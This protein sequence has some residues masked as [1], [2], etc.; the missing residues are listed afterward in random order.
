MSNALV[1]LRT[2][3]SEKIVLVHVESMSFQISRDLATIPIP[4]FHISSIPQATQQ[5]IEDICYSTQGHKF[6]MCP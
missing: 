1:F 5:K 4:N 2:P 6:V 3:Q